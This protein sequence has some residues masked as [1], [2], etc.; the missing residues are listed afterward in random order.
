MA[1]WANGTSAATLERIRREML[2]EMTS[3]E[4]AAAVCSNRPKY[5]VECWGL[6]RRLFDVSAAEVIVDSSS[7]S[8]RRAF[9]S[10]LEG[11][12][13]MSCTWSGTRGRWSTHW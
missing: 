8:G 12:S 6:I 9:C 3:V 4:A 1:P 2:E 10:R 7:P 5:L 13:C 11:L